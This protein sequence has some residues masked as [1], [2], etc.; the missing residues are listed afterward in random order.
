VA[1]L[2][3]VIDNCVCVFDHRVDVAVVAC[4]V[5]RVLSQSGLASTNRFSFAVANWPYGH[6]IEWFHVAHALA[7]TW[8]VDMGCVLK[9]SMLVKRVENG[10]FFLLV[11]SASRSERESMGGIQYGV[12]EMLKVLS[13]FW[14]PPA[15]LISGGRGG[16][17]WRRCRLAHE[18][19]TSAGPGS[20]SRIAAWTSLAM[21]IRSF[22][23]SK[24][25]L[26]HS[27]S[28]LLEGKNR[29]Q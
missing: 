1:F 5:A 20:V 18:M 23:S 9:W 6:L 26:V 22:I 29:Y 17:L 11:C 2:N 12:R 14:N 3:V 13:E 10:G 19:T 25:P 8:P 7:V 28:V 24:S 16:P 4:V 21:S 15:S 27:S